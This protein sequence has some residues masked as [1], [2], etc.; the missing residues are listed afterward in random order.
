MRAIVRVLKTPDSAAAVLSYVYRQRRGDDDVSRSEVVA[1]E[2]AAVGGLIAGDARFD[3]LAFTSRC[4]AGECPVCHAVI[5]AEAD[6]AGIE[7]KLMKS[8]HSW[9]ARFAPGRAHVVIVHK[10]DNDC[11]H[12]HAHVIIERYG[13]EGTVV[14]FSRADLREMVGMRFTTEFQAVRPDG[15][16]SP[17]RGAAPVYPHA[18]RLAAREV[19]ELL[20]QGET[21]DTL[22]ARKIITPARMRDGEIVSFV[23]DEK[24]LRVAT[25]ERLADGARKRRATAEALATKAR[26]NA[27]AENAKKLMSRGLC[28]LVEVVDEIATA[29]P[30]LPSSRGR[31]AR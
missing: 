6:V 3:A 1:W 31:G 13:P 4:P 18:R 10:K 25:V 5:S 7:N 17:H 9:A 8:G 16:P 15:S 30:T 26:A 14:H 28:D 29:E 19:A 2:G 27:L 12:P 11:S 24:R 23:Y 22:V 20:L 21:W